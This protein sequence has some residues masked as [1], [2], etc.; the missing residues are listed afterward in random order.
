MSI[1]D[2]VSK[3]MVACGQTVD[4]DNVAQGSLYIDLIAEEFDELNS[5]ETQEDELD[6]VCD[7]LYVLI[8]LANSRGYDITGAFREVHR[9]NMSKVD[10]STG[11]VLKREDGK[12]LK[13]STFSPPH[14]IPYVL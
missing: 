1:F 9:S 14:L 2:D 5:S 13:P 7:M 4:I 8:G 3:F 6:A 10:P 11:K 12:I